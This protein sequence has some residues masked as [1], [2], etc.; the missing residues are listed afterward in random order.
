MKLHGE[1][2]IRAPRL[3]VWDA[4][5][6]P[7]ILAKCIPGCEEVNKLSDSEFDVRI[8]AR[9]GPVRARFSGR[10]AMSDSVAPAS[11]TLAFEG[12]GG[13][14]GTAN[15]QSK[16]TLESEGES[17]RLQ[18]SV[19]AALGGKLGQVGGRLV[20]AS[21]KKLADDF[22]RAFS[23]QLAPQDITATSREADA[24]VAPPATAP[25]VAGTTSSGFG[26][27]WEGELQRFF[28]LALGCGIGFM[29]ARLLN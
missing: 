8:M 1:Q 3:R 17:T 21:A 24:T 4:L 28:W 2:L 5:N 25:V 14:A 29:V 20:E 10:M 9:I 16:V 6:D 12:S 26:A 7:Q 27:G 23:E 11:C 19:N 22:F 18:Y 15:G 13:A